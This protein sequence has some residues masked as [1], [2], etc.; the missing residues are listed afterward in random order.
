VHRRAAICLLV[1]FSF[2]LIE[3]ALLAGDG[4][5]LPACCRREGQHHCAM[6]AESTAAGPMVQA[7]CPAFPKTGAAPAHAK[8]AGMRPTRLMLEPIVCFAA[9]TVQAEAL[10]R[11]SFSRARQQRGPP[12]LLF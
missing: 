6:G 8:L 5:K 11:I 2:S 10:F 9:G 12:T 4:S 7:V 1:L 3:P